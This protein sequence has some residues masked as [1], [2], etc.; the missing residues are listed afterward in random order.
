MRTR[1]RG[2]SR[3]R[4]TRPD[5]CHSPFAAAPPCCARERSGQSCR[6]GPLA[7]S[8]HTRRAIR[9]SRR[10]RDTSRDPPCRVPS[11]RRRPCRNRGRPRTPACPNIR[12]V[13]RW[14]DVS[15]FE[16]I[17]AHV[18]GAQQAHTVHLSTDQGRCGRRQ[19][20]RPTST[21][22]PDLPTRRSC[23]QA[24]P[25]A[26]ARRAPPSRRSNCPS[27]SN[28]QRPA[29]RARFSRGTTKPVSRMPSG[30]KMR[31]SRTVAETMHLR[32]AR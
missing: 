1:V 13:A 8:R 29:R 28:P 11:P 24:V 21:R 17:M 9:Q 25:R 2:T 3:W 30:L 19:D 31:R 20:S 26:R 15:W 16:A 6:S 23:R 27:A 22:D 4:S 12:A 14:S 18:S 5:R 10:R 32:D 7:T